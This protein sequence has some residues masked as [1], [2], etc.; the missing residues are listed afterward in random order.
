LKD[1][2]ENLS[3]V[4]KG[5]HCLFGK[6]EALESEK[7]E[8]MKLRKIIEKLRRKACDLKEELLKKQGVS[9]NDLGDSLYYTQGTRLMG[10][11]EFKIEL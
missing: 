5:F 10:W 3:E 8:N 1:T 9:E 6:S 7:K 11:N 2:Q 4:T